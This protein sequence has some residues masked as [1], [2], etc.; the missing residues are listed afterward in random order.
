MKQPYYEH[1]GITILHADC[2]DVLPTVPL[3]DFV[4]TDPPYEPFANPYR[5]SL[6]LLGSGRLR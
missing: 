6:N 1:D 5:P 3:C 4:L 2:R